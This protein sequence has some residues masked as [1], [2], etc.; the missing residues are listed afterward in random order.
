MIITISKLY[1][2]IYIYYLLFPLTY[3]ELYLGWKGLKEL[4]KRPSLSDDVQGA[5]SVMTS[6]SDIHV[7]SGNLRLVCEARGEPPPDVFWTRENK[8][9]ILVTGWRDGTRASG[10]RDIH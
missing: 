3:P 4:L 10:R 9:K 8:D 1:D 5:A 6:D 2:N 7:I